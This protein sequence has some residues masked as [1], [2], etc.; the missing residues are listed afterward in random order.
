M[1]VCVRGYEPIEIPIEL[2]TKEVG[3]FGSETPYLAK[4]ATRLSKRSYLEDKLPS[5]LLC[6]EYL[7]ESILDRDGYASFLEPLAGIGLSARIFGQ[8]CPEA[9]ALN[10]FDTGCV[11]VLKHNFPKADV[12]QESVF[13]MLLPGSDVIFL[14]FNDFT[15]KR[16][17]SG[18]P[19]AAVLNRAFGT[20]QKYVV[21]NDCSIF[22]FR[23]GENSYK[24]YSE[25]MGASISSEVDYFKATADYWASILKDWSVV[26]VAYFKDSAFT[27]FA[28]NSV[29]RGFGVH[30]VQPRQ[31]LTPPVV[32]VR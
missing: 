22:Y 3:P 18:H 31:L 30:K 27:L 16:Y 11:K 2:I 9:L 28:R 7:K 32:T 14:D 23:Y 19:Y 6:L 4:V 17:Q 21:L 25:L 1:K 20:A 5:K 8:E 26:Q 10:D 15:M 12:T 24:V 13:G 29:A